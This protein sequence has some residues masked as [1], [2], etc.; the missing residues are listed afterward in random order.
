[1]RKSTMRTFEAWI[2]GATYRSRGRNGSPIWTTGG[3]VYSYNTP[4]ARFTQASDRR[5][6]FNSQRYSVTTT[7]HQRGMLQLMDG[8]G[9]LPTICAT[10]SEYKA[11]GE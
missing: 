11:N 10:E 9:I 4:I 2:K 7:V 1:M 3:V 6:V 5:A 8:S